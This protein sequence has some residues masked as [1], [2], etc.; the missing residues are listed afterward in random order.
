MTEILE[1]SQFAENDRVTEV[2]VGTAGVATELH[3]EG[4]AGCDGPLELPDEI[5]FGDDLRGASFDEVHLFIDGGKQFFRVSPS[6]GGSSQLVSDVTLGFALLDRFSFV[7]A[8]LSLCD[9]QLDLGICSLE[10]DRQGNDGQTFFLNSRQQSAYLP[11]AQQ[12][13]ACPARVVIAETTMFIRTDVHPEEP[14]FSILDKCVAV[15]EIGVPAAERLDFR[16]L[17]DEPGFK[18]VEYEIVVPRLAI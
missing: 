5:F 7:V 15:L 12:Q 16:T 18:C 10:V 4:L 3:A 13:F 6:V 9:R 1:L 11:L 14:N 8:F 2:K 17:Q